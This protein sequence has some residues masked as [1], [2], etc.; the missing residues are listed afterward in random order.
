VAEIAIFIKTFFREKALFNCIDSIKKYI[1]N[2]SYRLYI[3]DDGFI[4]D[5]KK[6]LYDKL[7]NE[8]HIIKILP[9][10]TGASK[11][12][13]ILL[14]SLKDEKY[15]LRMDDDFEFYNKTNIEAMKKI[16]E[17]KRKIGAVA[18]LE[19]QVGRG[20]EVGFDN[21]SIFQGFL[22]NKGD[23]L[24]KRIVPLK[25]FEYSDYNGIKYARCDLTRNM[26]LLRREV[27]NVIKWEE[28]LKFNG[29]HIDFLLQ[30]KNSGWDLV[31]TPNSIHIHRGDFKEVDYYY[32]KHLVN[33]RNRDSFEREKIL[34]NKYSY[35]K[36]KIVEP[37]S[38]GKIYNFF[39]EGISN[40]KMEFKE[41]LR[42]G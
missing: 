15:I 38:A 21:I 37:I 17:C 29:E 5:G 16:L 23:V 19:K 25:K 12:R 24:I 8:G 26:I 36:V 14:K 33:I 32:F 42:G 30:L 10:D 20:K 35:K 27:F 34:Y 2:V 3:A 4:S 18:D 22:E 1:G 31:F 11:S 9:Y 39:R 6:E 28:K 13:N 41:F 7:K 40:L